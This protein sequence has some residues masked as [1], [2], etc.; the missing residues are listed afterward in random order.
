MV[1]IP[2]PDVSSTPVSRAALRG[3]WA[4]L[5]ADSPASSVADT[6]RPHLAARLPDVGVTQL[7]QF[8]DQSVAMI[9]LDL[10]DAIFHRPPSRTF[11]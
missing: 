6:S 9:A 1:L 8:F 10:D 2:R 11:S 4:P 7:L 5:R 3:G